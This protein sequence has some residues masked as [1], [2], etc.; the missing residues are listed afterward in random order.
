VQVSRVNLLRPAPDV[1]AHGGSLGRRW[2]DLAACLAIVA[3][4]SGG[5]IWWWSWLQRTG[6]LAE[7]D[8]LRAKQELTRLRTTITRSDA[9]SR[10]SDALLQRIELLE[11]LHV[12]QSDTL[13]TLEA[14][15]S[16]IPGSCWLTSVVY[17][18]GVP[19]RIDG[20][21]RQ[22]GSIFE[23]SERLEASRAFEGGI[24]VVESRLETNDEDGPLVGFSIEAL[25]GAKNRVRAAPASPTDDRAGTDR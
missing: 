7:Q 5:L 9:R 6:S 18:A 22:L 1:R 19:V 20:R 12:R 13:T 17:E 25:S 3:L 21:A 8:L 14:I 15:G 4:T 2:N 24:H 16:T 23:F 10:E 11:S